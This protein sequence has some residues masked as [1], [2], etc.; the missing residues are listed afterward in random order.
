M[1]PED[2]PRAAPPVV[3]I[4]GQESDNEALAH[5]L[6]LDGYDA[7]P[8]SDLAMLGDVDL[9]VFGRA[10]QRGAALGALRA[11]RRGELAGSGARILWMSTSSDPS[12]T[13]R[14]FEAGADDVI[15]APFVYAEVLARLRAL[16]R[17]DART[18]TVIEFDALRID[19]SARVV[20]FDAVPVALRR[21][22][23][24]LLVHIARAP[25]R[26]YSRAELLSEVWGYRTG[27]TR[28]LDSHASRLRRA[29][30]DAG[31]EG[32]VCSTW[33]VG[34]RLAP[35]PRD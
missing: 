13:L 19:T 14:A 20:T 16:L 3:V 9:I 35:R 23:H 34:Y 33:G 32:W 6:A 24:A 30:A 5:E 22:E 15:R 18:P 4:Y 7:R 27:T 8:V 25:A 26:V 28:T 17:R 12:D 21:R 11:L 29:L 10:S 1:Q 31:A 2:I